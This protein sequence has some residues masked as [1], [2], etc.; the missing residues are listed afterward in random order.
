M[1]NTIEIKIEC[2]GDAVGT[3]GWLNSIISSGELVIKENREGVPA[4]FLKTGER[5][6]YFICR[7]RQPDDGENV[8]R[9]DHYSDDILACFPVSDEY[10]YGFVDYTLTNAAHEKVS[11][12]INLAVT[13][14]QEWWENDK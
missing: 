11:E 6:Y 9:Y 4:M 1:K 7:K 14:F 10:S 3:L 8:E 5:G 12:F 13:K 2:K